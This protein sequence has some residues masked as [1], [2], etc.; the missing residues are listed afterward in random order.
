MENFAFS[1][2]LQLLQIKVANL[3]D[4]LQKIE[5]EVNKDFN[6]ELEQAFASYQKLRDDYLALV[7][8]YQPEKIYKVQGETDLNLQHEDLKQEFFKLQN[9]YVEL[10]QKLEQQEDTVKKSPKLVISEQA[11]KTLAKYQLPNNSVDK[12]SQALQEVANKKQ[13]NIK[14]IISAGI[15]GGVLGLFI[16]GVYWG[17]L[18]FFSNFF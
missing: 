8:Q 1:D 9:S 14:Q 10:R 7:K 12:L 6:Q 11:L 5:D 13:D 3:Q 15:K 17:S 18:V 4:K 16:A 2:S